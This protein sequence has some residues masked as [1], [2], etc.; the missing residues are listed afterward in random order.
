MVIPKELTLN[1]VLQI[2]KDNSVPFG[3]IWDEILTEFGDIAVEKTRVLFFTNSIFADTRNHIPDQHKKD[4][5]TI[6]K[7]CGIAIQRH[8]IRDF[9]AFLVLTY[10]NSP[11]DARTMLYSSETFTRLSEK[12]GTRSLYGGFAP[13]GLDAGDNCFAHAHIG[14]GASGS[15]EDIL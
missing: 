10:L 5:K 7:E 6:G 15:S 13:S 4:V 1:K 11:E 14:V 8:E 12:M 2:A 9:M 3:H